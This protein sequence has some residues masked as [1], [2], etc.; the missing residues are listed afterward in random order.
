MDWVRALGSFA[1]AIVA[2]LLGLGLR[3]WVYRPKLVLSSND[4]D[5]SARI[6]M[7]L[8]DGKQGGWCRV[9]VANNGKATARNVRARILSIE[10]H[11]DDGWIL[12]RA[13]LDARS[14]GWANTPANEI[15]DIP[16]DTSRPLDL[17]AV[18]RAP[19][20]LSDAM[21][22][23][24]I[25]AGAAFPT[26]VGALTSEHGRNQTFVAQSPDTPTSGGH[27]ITEAGS[28]RLGIVLAGDNVKAEAFYF[29]IGFSADWWDPEAGAGYLWSRTVK[30]DGPT[31]EPRAI[32]SP[33]QPLPTCS[34]TQSRAID[35]R[36]SRPPARR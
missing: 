25:S 7:R 1:A 32:H 33:P 35:S 34:K 21:M 5:P 18:Q 3:D 12:E 8:A 16:A 28:W 23:I 36:R 29:R 9:R 11:T 14:L 15:V 17:L 4:S 6:V 26:I 24:T 30:I 27:Q 31:S 19:E 2:L 20:T 22:T 10:R 13:E